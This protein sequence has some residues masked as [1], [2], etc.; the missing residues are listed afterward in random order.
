MMSTIVK[1]GLGLTL[2]GATGCAQS[3]ALEQVSDMG[4]VQ[5]ATAPTGWDGATVDIEPFEDLRPKEAWRVGYAKSATEH[6]EHANAFGEEGVVRVGDLEDEYPALLARALP[7]G[8]Q[9]SL[10][11]A[12]TSEFVVRGRLVKTTMKYAV[13]PILVVPAIIGVP[14]GRSSIEMNVAV[15]LYRRG[16]ATPIWTEQYTYEKRHLEGHYYGKIEDGELARTALRDSVTR[17]AQDLTNVVAAA[18]KRS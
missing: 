10:G 1:W 9:V 18:R 2:V 5:T 12:G 16:D 8:A 4:V 17:A 7:P 14:Y 11:T 15:E 6:P 13:R 3:S